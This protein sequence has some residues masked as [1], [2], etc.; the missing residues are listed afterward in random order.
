MYGPRKPQWLG[1]AGCF[2]GR[3]S[4]NESETKQVGNDV[5]C[6]SRVIGTRI[7]VDTSMSDKNVDQAKQYDHT[8]RPDRKI[9][10]LPAVRPNWEA[11]HQC[12]KKNHRKNKHEHQEAPALPPRSQC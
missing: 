2:E 4:T 1:T 11:A 9:A 7:S 5:R 12:D 6:A 3:I 8:N 10:P